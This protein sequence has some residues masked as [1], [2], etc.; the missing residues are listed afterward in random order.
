M[1]YREIIAL[2]PEM[3]TKHI[4]TLCRQIVELLRATICF[5][6][7]ARLPARKEQLGYHGA[8][9]HEIGYLSIFRKSV[10]RKF[11]FH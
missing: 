9:F 10:T 5:V 2:C 1:L 8:D 4:N 7:S 3:H 6:M 11:K